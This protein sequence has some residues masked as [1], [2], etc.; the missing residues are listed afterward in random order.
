MNN[1][2]FFLFLFQINNFEFLPGTAGPDTN[3]A[4]DR[5][6]YKKENKMGN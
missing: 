4:N 1:C 6:I 3:G 2:K 5:H